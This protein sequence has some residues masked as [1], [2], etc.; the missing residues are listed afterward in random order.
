MKMYGRYKYR[1]VV[2]MAGVVR[3]VHVVRLVLHVALVAR[4][5]GAADDAGRG[6]RGGRLGPAPVGHLRR[7]RRHALATAACSI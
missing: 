5:P 1:V 7:S 6:G 2:V 4:G 3:V